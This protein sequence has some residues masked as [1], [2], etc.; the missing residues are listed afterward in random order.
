MLDWS[1]VIRHPRRQ[2]KNNKPNKAQHDNN[3]TRFESNF[4]HDLNPRPTV[5]ARLP[6]GGML[7]LT[8]TER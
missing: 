7:A 2:G 8:F 4:H 5:N 6:S 1:F 3:L